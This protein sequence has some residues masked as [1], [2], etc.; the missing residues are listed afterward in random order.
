MPEDF[1][2]PCLISEGTRE[3]QK[4]NIFSTNF[5][6]QRYGTCTVMARTT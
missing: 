5:P 2:L 3:E 1:P 4:L 6:R